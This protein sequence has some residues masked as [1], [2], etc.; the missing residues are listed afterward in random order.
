MSQSV[1]ANS[2]K[3]ATEKFVIFFARIIEVIDYLAQLVY[4]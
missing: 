2:D 1:A 4:N 3:A